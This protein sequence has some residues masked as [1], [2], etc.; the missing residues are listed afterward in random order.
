MSPLQRFLVPLIAAAAPAFALAQTMAIPVANHSFEADLAPDGGFPVVIPASWSLYDPGLIVDQATN[1][2]GVLNPTGTDFFTNPNAVPDGRNAALIYLEQEAGTTAVGDPV[3]LFQSLGTLLQAHTR[4][5]LSVD[6]GNIASGTGLGAYSGFGFADLSSFPGYRLELLAGG[7]V[8][9]FDHNSQ[10][11]AEGQFGTATVLAQIGAEHAQLGQAL[12]IRLINLNATG[13]LNERGREVDF[14]QVRL[15]AAAVPEP[16][17]YALW[18]GGISLLAFWGRN[19]RRTQ[20]A[21]A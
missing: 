19:R 10:T 16:A 7:A 11:I 6:V 17:T 20:N 3:G 12:G 9:A 15:I 14:D 13:N 2:V 8:I 21:R 4:Y 18:L 5:T 1:A